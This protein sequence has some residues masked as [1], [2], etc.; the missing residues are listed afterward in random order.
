[1]IRVPLRLASLSM[2]LSALLFVPVSCS[3]TPGEPAEEPEEEEEEYDTY[4]ETEEPNP[5]SWVAVDGQGNSL[6]PDTGRYPDVSDRKERTVGIFYFL[7]HGCHGYDHIEINNQVMAPSKS[8]MKSPFDIQKLLDENPAEPAFGPLESMHHWGEPY[9][10]Y[11]V[12]ND[13]WVIRKHAQMLVDAGVDVLFFDVTNLCHYLPVV[14]NLSRVY[15]Q[16]RAEGNKTPQY[17]FLLN[18]DTSDRFEA[19]YYGLYA[20]GKYSDLWFKWDGKPL[21]LANP[22]AVPEKYHSDF[23]FRHSWFLWNNPEADAW[24][25]NGEDKWPWGGM[26]PQQAGKHGGKNEF[27]SVMPAT[28]PTSNVGRSFDVIS[29]TEPRIKTPEKGIYFKKQFE[30]AMSLN[31]QF[32]FFTGWNEWTAQ[33][34]DSS[35]GVTPPYFV[36]Q[37]NHE[38]SRDIEPLAGD[39]GDNYYYLMADF[40]RK[41]KGTKRL[42]TFTEK[43]E[44]TVDGKF[45]EW[46]GVVAKWG[47]DKGDVMHRDH[48]GWGRIGV[49][50]NVTGRN[51]ILLTKVVNDG[52]NLYFYVKT[53]SDITSCKDPQWMQLF[54]RVDGKKVNWEGYD[55]VVNRTVSSEGTSLLEKCEGG[56]K[57]SKAADVSFKVYGK[58]MELAVPLSALGI[59]DTKKFTV[60]FKWVDNAAAGGDIQTCMRDGDSAPNGRFRYRYKFNS[61]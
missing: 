34:F 2:L 60:D 14:E 47:D 53:A 55:F 59:A 40:I 56:W 31:P 41:F 58:E 24:F 13:D 46:S 18:T 37:Y 30:Q 1:M 10:G 16:M 20:K 29:N 3:K 32:M 26:Y 15:M 45:D 27:V 35:Y 48:Y 38:F 33:R 12:M 21:V 23:T 39:F 7:W 52:T 44:V 61:E 57:W 49:Y 9:L 8:D 51:D 36:D 4:G 11:Y 19:I 43:K 25:E 17:A 28:H 42:P 50:T 5:F 54:L 6:D 22:D